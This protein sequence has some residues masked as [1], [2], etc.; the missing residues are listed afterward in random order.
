MGR[1]SGAGGRPRGA[2]D[3]F[4]LVTNVVEW[5]GGTRDNCGRLGGGR[6]TILVREQLEHLLLACS[7]E[8]NTTPNVC[9]CFD[10]RPL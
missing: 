9:L 7:F 8:H 3:S 10:C 2:R 6:G 5:D 4:F 1:E